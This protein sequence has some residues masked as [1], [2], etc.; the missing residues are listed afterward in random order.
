[1]EKLKDILVPQKGKHLGDLCGWGLHGSYN[2]QGVR[3]LA[4]KHGILDDLGFPNLSPIS[5]YRRAVKGSVKR[6]Q[7]DDRQ[8]DIVK[9][10]DTPV[11]IVHAV[12][13][14]EV[15]DGDSGSLSKKDASSNTIFRVGFDKQAY[16]DGAAEDTLMQ[17]E[18]QEHPVAQKMMEMYAELCL[19]FLPADVRVAFQRAFEKWGAMRLLD[20][21]GLWWIPE[22]NAH[23]VRSWR[24]FMREL[25][26]DTI[27][28]P[29]F[30]TVETMESLIAQ[31]QSTLEGQLGDLL[32]QLETFTRKD[33]TRL[34]TLESR[35][36]VFDDLRN[37]IELHAMVLGTKQEELIKKLNDAQQGLI[38]SLQNIK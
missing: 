35:V 31:S 3:S 32:D 38:A 10:D 2:Q 22:P 8:F 1:M 6:G 18:N 27:V 36:E 20:H 29:I 21:G 25:E 13:E 30:D 9:L 26:N 7:V 5:A 12:V 37:K 17:V 28:I 11:K 34:S 4:E 15:V 16:T 23:K 14:T 24:E 33:N 19:Q